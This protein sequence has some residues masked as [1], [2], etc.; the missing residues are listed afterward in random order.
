VSRYRFELVAAVN[1]VAYLAMP[2]GFAGGSM[3]N[4]RFFHPAYAVAVIVL[5]PRRVGGR[6]LRLAKLLAA[7]VPLAFLVVALPQFAEADRSNR[8][9]DRL[10]PEIAMNSSVAYLEADPHRGTRSFATAT[11]GSRALVDRGGRLVFALSY[12]VI[13]PVRVTHSHRWDEAER[14]MLENSL[15]FI[16]SHD[17]RMFRYV[18]V[19]SRDPGAVIII[20][21]AM[22]EASFVDSSGEWSLYESRLP[23]IPLLAPEPPLPSPRPESLHD[24]LDRIVRAAIS[25]KAPADIDET[26]HHV[27]WNPEAAP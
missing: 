22:P 11:E 10:L 13:S 18:I 24:R 21:E 19:H 23:V 17:L 2:Y 7:T 16:P 4:H 6:D 3:F 25:A 1:G 27:E 20:P 9:L 8:E 12:S 15:T 26:T 14:R 5:A